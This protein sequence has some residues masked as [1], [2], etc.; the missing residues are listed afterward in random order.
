MTARTVTELRALFW[1]QLRDYSPE[2]AKQHKPRR[3]QNDYPADIRAA[4]VDF[5]DG[6]HRR[7]NISDALAKRATL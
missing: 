6:E 5:V 1:Q 4:W 3:R 2:L 7:G